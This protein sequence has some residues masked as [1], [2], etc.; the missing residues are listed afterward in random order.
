M[1][2]EGRYEKLG[3]VVD[4]TLSST[5]KGYVSN[6]EP[7]FFHFLVVVAFFAIGYMDNNIVVWVF[8]VH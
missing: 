8:K 1:L 6:W 7:I 4:Y 3:M 5:F 2:D